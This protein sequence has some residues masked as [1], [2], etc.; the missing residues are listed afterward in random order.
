MSGTKIQA[1][2]VRVV[3]GDTIRVKVADREE[4]LRILALDTEESRSGSSKPI[5]PWGKKAKEEAKQII[6]AG[7]TVTL[8]FPGNESADFCWGKYRGNYGRPLVFLYLSDGTDF[9]E[10]MIG[11]GFSPYFVKYGY[12][13]HRKNHERYIVAERR[14]QV[15]YIGVWDQIG[16]NGSE[17]RNYPMLGV[18]WSLR[19][20]IIEEYRNYQ[21]N[22][23]DKPIW[24]TRLEYQDLIELAEGEKEVTIFTELKDFKRVGGIHGIIGIGSIHQPFTVFLPNIDD[25]SG[26]KIISLLQNRYIPSGLNHLRRSYAYI[27]GKLMMYNGKPEIIL[28]DVEQI[29]DSANDT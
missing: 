22:Y 9:Q 19:A 18:W 28:T 15:K 12:A 27:T 26:Q 11:N 14:A 13:V 6:H 21:K 4:S 3:D 8:E 23:P 10:H 7:D 16:V 20:R 17:M 29:K 5:T 25:P 24:N 1:E 2:V